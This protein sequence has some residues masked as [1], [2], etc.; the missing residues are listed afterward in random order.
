[1]AK[2]IVLYE[3]SLC[4]STGICGPNPDQALVALQDTIDKCKELGIETERLQIT[5]HPK[6]YMENIEVMKLMQQKQLTCLPITS[7]D[8][9]IIKS[10]SYPN[11]DDLQPYI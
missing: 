3:P 9:K 4:C 6:R 1:M 11:M 8:G 5:T 2:K 7:V 10:G